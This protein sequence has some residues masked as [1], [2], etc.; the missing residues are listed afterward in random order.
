MHDDH[1]LVIKGFLYDIVNARGPEVRLQIGPGFAGAIVWLEK[2][3]KSKKMYK[4]MEDKS[5]NAALIIA[6]IKYIADIAKGEDK[7]IPPIALDHW[8][9]RGKN[10]IAEYREYYKNKKLKVH[11]KL[12]L[13]KKDPSGRVLLD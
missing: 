4:I 7:D 10:V 5:D 9:E 8:Y 12:E 3:H 11:W 13:K 2:L 1:V 6:S